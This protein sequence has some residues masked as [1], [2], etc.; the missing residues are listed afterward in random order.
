MKLLLMELVSSVKDIKY[1]FMTVVTILKRR[2]WF[3]VK[4]HMSY[5]CLCVYPWIFDL[6]SVLF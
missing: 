5:L 4:C 1:Y 3:P 6:Y 2:N